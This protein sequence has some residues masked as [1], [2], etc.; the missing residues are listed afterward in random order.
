MEDS[1]FDLVIAGGR[2]MDPETGRDEVCNVGVVDGTITAITDEPLWGTTTID[3]TG[4]MH[5]QALSGTKQALELSDAA[6]ANGIRVIKE[7]YP[8][9]FGASICG[10]DYLHPDNYGPNMGRSYS[11]IIETATPQ[12]LTKERYDHLMKANPEALIMF[13]GATDADMDARLVHPTTVIGSDAF[14]MTITET[15]K[16]VPR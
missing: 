13:Y 14:P 12:P 2:V 9:N 3:A 10:A 4:H 15:S 11:D 6:R 8:Y 5:Q 1:N 7:I 16:G